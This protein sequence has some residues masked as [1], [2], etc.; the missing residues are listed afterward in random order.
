MLEKNKN[1]TIKM[2]DGLGPPLGGG[3][4]IYIKTIA[5]NTQ[6]L[7]KKT[8]FACTWT[9]KPTL[10]GLIAINFN[11]YYKLRAHYHKNAVKQSIVWIFNDK[12]KDICL[13]NLLFTSNVKLHLSLVPIVY[14]QC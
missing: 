10:Q 5:M 3:G 2:I 6:N 7:A 14:S 1:I 9:I 8:N 13:W 4:V 12:L 11:Y